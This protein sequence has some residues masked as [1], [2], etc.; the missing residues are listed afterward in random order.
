MGRYGHGIVG[1]LGFF[2]HYIVKFDYAKEEIELKKR[3]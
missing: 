3:T 2:D 1:Q